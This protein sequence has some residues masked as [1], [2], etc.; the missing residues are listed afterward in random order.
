M[1]KDDKPRY[2]S[3]RSIA[4]LYD[5]SSKTL[6]NW[7]EAGKLNYLRYCDAEDKNTQNS[8]RLYDVE[9]LAALLQ[10][11]ATAQ[12]SIVAGSVAH[13]VAS[14]VVVTLAV[15][16]ARAPWEC[17]ARGISRL[18]LLCFLDLRISYF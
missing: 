3:A 6:R 12:N 13:T 7:A 14:L 8:R 11:D 5:I 9:Q 18:L 1:G 17:S 15:S 10:D 2:L 16:A 4:K